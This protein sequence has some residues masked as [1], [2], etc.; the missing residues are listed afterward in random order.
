MAH[1]RNY[2]DRTG[3][4][5]NRVTF[6]EFADRAKNGNARWKV[7]CDCG[8]EFIVLATNVTYGSTKS[9]GCYRN[10]KNRTE[11]LKRRKHR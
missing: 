4:K 2:K 6:L 9:C 8:T 7:R 11:G 3:Q 10:E 5:Y 1:A